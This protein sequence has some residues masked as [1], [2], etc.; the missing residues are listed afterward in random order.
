[1]P[2]FSSRVPLKLAPTSDFQPEEF[3]KAVFT[4]GLR[5]DWEQVAQCP[6]TVRGLEY[7]G[8]GS[9]LTYAM[10]AAGKISHTGEPRV[11]CP[12]CRGNGYILHSKQEVRAVI[13]SARSNPK[14]F[15][16]YG[17]YA[18]GM[19][20]LSL[21]PEH[22]P[23]FQD[24]FTLLD[25]VL[26]Y[27]ETMRFVPTVMSL[28][29]PI[30]SRTLDLAAGPTDFAGVLHCFKAG[31]DGEVALGATELT[32]G[33]DF[34]VTASGQ[35]DWTLGVALG[36]APVTGAPFSVSYYARP[37]F[38]VVDHPHSIRDTWIKRKTP[39]RTYQA[40]PVQAMARL[41]FLGALN[42]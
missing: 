32:E 4:H 35:I 29:Y 27:R 24:R 31:V 18:E 13:T 21:L 6:C 37:R 7:T 15:A 16:I 8:S 36:S 20:S 40:L 11:D 23:C 19:I 5:L 30:V 12:A 3:R 34:E 38:A 17:E 9:K 41:E 2:V 26:I 28:R 22:L 25:S 10:D 42:S 1:M 39:Q 14:P 33:V